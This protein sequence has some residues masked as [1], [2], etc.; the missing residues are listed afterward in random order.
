MKPSTPQTNVCLSLTGRHISKRRRHHL[1]H[2]HTNFINCQYMRIRPATDVDLSPLLRRIRPYEDLSE[3]NVCHNSFEAY[4][5][6]RLSFMCFR[7][8]STSASDKIR[9]SCRG[10]PGT[11]MLSVP[12]GNIPIRQVLSGSGL[13]SAGV[14]GFLPILNPLHQSGRSR[15]SFA[16]RNTVASQ[17]PGL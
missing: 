6:S 2:E 12:S 9:G 8:S 17:G 13:T 10:E 3:I 1:R 15:P 7:A 4:Q 11:T 16:R 14:F 5:D